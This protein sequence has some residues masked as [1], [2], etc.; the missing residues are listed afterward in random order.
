MPPR[1]ARPSDPLK[2]RFERV[3]LIRLRQ[4]GDVVFTT[5]LIRALRQQFAG[6]H[7]AYL[8]EPA[9]APIVAGNP[10]LDEIIVAPAPRGL[11][12][13]RHELAL[14]RRLRAERYDL[15]I[16]LHGGP[17]ASTLTWLSGAP[18]RIGY[19]VVGRWWMYTHRVGRARAL[20][21]RHS[22]RNQWDLLAPLGFD[23]P[24]PDAFPVEM[25]VSTDATL[26]VAM[27]LAG[28]GVTDGDRLIVVHVS[29]GNPFRRWPLGHFA[30]V[31]A[32]LAGVRGRRV[33]VTAG[34]S[35]RGA[36]QAVID[37]ARAQLPDAARDGVL[38][39]GEFS[40]AE[41]RALVERAALYIGGDSGPLHVA[42]T[43]H[44]PVVALF[45]PTL[46][47]RSMP[48]RSDRWSAE[49]VQVDGLPCRPCDQR[50]CLPGDFRCL[51]GIAPQ[52]VIQ[53]AER[54]LA[55]AHA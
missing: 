54:A 21:P 11:R 19:D 43:S 26:A 2:R 1:D 33:A 20:V 12:G 7:L 38:A 51:T 50:V 18:A 9:A 17:R 37:Q 46:P 34:P 16:D 10:H 32:A 14:I 4:V 29:A 39:C 27:K 24:E 30:D 6:A 42:A 36:A 13:I 3:L 31:V 41:L 47:E 35:E 45:G 44:V 28:A 48:W 22:V 55:A 15:A 23:P 53:A 8:V 49:A 5:P 52:R 25:A 40:L